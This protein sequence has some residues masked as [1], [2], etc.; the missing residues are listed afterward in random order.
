M[1]T[2]VLDVVGLA[3]RFGEV[4]ALDGASLRVGAGEFVVVLGPTGAGKTTLLR[5]IA[6]LESPDAGQIRLLG[7][8]AAGIAPADRDVALVF[9][10]FSL[11]PGRTAR[12]NLEFPLRAPGRRLSRAEI[13]ERVAWAAKL[14]KIEPLLDRPARLLSG[15]EMQRVAIGRAIVRRPRLFLMDEPL[16]NL[17]AKL[18]EE[19]RLE[20]RELARGL[21]TPVVWVTHDQI[22]A[23]SMADRVVVLCEGRVL[24]DAPPEEVYL[25]PASPTAAK[26]FGSPPM[27]VIDVRRSEGWWVSP[28]G[29]RVAAARPGSEDRAR[30][31][32]RAEHVD[33]WSGDSEGTVE[34]VE[35]LGPA[36]MLLVR[37]A[38][39]S[40]H[41]LVDRE[42]SAL[43]GD[44]LRPGIPPERVIVWPAR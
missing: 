32:F 7:E 19:L 17:D 18:R 22:E 20:L 13:A 30:I 6:G 35:D 34:V 25:R 1:S 8:D 11:Y 23:L 31:G 36:R 2:P 28:D 10:N 14:L 12:Q 38:G 9:Q 15:G 37:W 43:Q 41:V 27:N 24:Q 40:V 29:T 5:A 33:P 16:S 42:T 44:R 26:L 3:K 39:E 21:G 4:L